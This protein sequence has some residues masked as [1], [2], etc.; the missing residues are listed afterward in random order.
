MK[1]KKGQVPWNK[2]T[3]NPPTKEEVRLYNI[4]YHKKHRIRLIANAK[5]YYQDHK[6]EILR[7][8]CEEYAN[9]P[10]YRKEKLLSIHRSYQKNKAQRQKEKREY[11][12]KNAK[13]LL[14]LMKERYIN[15]REERLLASK[16]YQS[17]PENKIRRNQY[18]RKY[19]KE[20]YPNDIQY[21]LA[22]II[23]ARLYI[24]LKSKKT[25]K[26]ASGV[27][28]IGCSLGELKVYL[29]SLFTEGMTWTNH[30]LT[31]WHIDHKKPLALFDLSDKKQFLQAVHYT[32]LQPLWA[33]KNLSKGKRI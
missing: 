21:R 19:H 32:N 4:E 3:G 29:E 33:T 26:I 8:S 22:N 20:K 30:S 25:P 11:H 7:R 27:R 2:G 28:D 6:E 24:A 23:R 13:R 15:N 12:H 1:Y 14:P 16:I 10:E 17:K 18:L 9:N 31:G 5:R